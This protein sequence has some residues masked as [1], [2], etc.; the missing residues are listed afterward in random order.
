MSQSG[1]AVRGSLVVVG[2][3]IRIVGQLTIEAI[4]WMKNADKL[5]YLVGDE[6]AEDTVIQMNP[7][8]A[9]SLLDFYGFGKPRME[10]YQGMVARILACVHEGLRTCVAFYGHPGVFA[11]PGHEAIRQ[12]RLQGYSAHML[13]AISA[14]DCLFADLGIDPA[15]AGCQSY[16]ATDFLLHR[17]LIDPTS[18]V[19]LWQVGVVGDIT[20]K[21]DKYD[22]W[23]LPK[24]IERLREFYPG[25]HPCRIYQAAIFPG[26]E[27]KVQAITIATLTEARLTSASTLCILPGRSSMPDPR[28]ESLLAERQPAAWNVGNGAV[29]AFDP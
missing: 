14:E 2:T 20:Y 4:G 22:A 15:T 17:R 5:L 1:E 29:H 19:I 18:V 27:A 16:E 21:K 13:P 23:A 28:F 6:F 9:E 7:G 12:A 10:S 26:E 25:D 8:R 24:L 11:Y 3:G